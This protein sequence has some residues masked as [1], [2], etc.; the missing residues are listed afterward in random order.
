[1]AIVVS[2][3]EAAKA[4][5]LLAEAGETAWRIGAVCRRRGNGPQTVIG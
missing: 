1:M 4:E 5:T 3:A 2:P